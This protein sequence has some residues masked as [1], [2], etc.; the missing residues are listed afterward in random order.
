MEIEE[1]VT[2]KETSILTMSTF[3]SA[4]YVNLE[5]QIIKLQDNVIVSEV[6]DKSTKEGSEALSSHPF[7]YRLASLSH[8]KLRVTSTF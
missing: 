5:K 2:T 6:R 7:S 8:H 1:D 4:F 3:F